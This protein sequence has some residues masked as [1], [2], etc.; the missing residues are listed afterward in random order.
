MKKKRPRRKPARPPGAG[1]TRRPARAAAAGPLQY[2]V[3]ELSVVD[4]QTLERTLNEWVG[5]GWRLD[6]VQFAMRES[7]RR[8]A[9]A[10]VLFTREAPAGAS[11]AAGG[12]ERAARERLRRLAEE[13]S[14]TAALA[15][16]AP[17]AAPGRALDPRER[18]AQL[19]GLHEADE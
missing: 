4:E 7:S 6:G 15:R 9:M 14:P 3:V 16:E 19:A 11:E 8:P 12:D 1:R 18:L 10:F 13:G 17:A 5:E 2:K